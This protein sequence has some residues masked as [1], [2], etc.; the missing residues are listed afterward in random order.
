MSVKNKT[1]LL[2]I[3]L[4]FWYC[5]SF[6]KPYLNSADVSVVNDSYGEITGKILELLKE[7]GNKATFFVLGE[8]AEENPQLIKKIYENGHEI[9]IHG[10][11]HTAANDLSPDAFTSEIQRSLEIIKSI[12]PKPPIG[13]RA[14]NFSLDQH[15]LAA[16]K[17]L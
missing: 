1:M 5:G 7:T 14:P 13:Y 12:I 16:L 17:V 10:Y 3:D 9:A 6:L 11:S 15:N 2:T 4:E 8:L